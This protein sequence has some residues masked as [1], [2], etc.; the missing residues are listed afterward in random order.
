ME[1]KF[2]AL[3]SV[4]V[5]ISCICHVTGGIASNDTHRNEDDKAKS[6]KTPEADKE[7]VALPRLHVWN[8]VAGEEEW[9]IS[10]YKHRENA[11]P[12]VDPQEGTVAC[13]SKEGLKKSKERRHLQRAEKL[14]TDAFPCLALGEI[15]FVAIGRQHFEGNDSCQREHHGKLPA[16]A[17]Q[18]NEGGGL[19]GDSPQ[20]IAPDAPDDSVADFIQ[21]VYAV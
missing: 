21:P 7:S 4:A 12:L 8:I 3:L 13:S 6:D 16:H 10:G 11:P 2:H 1:L 18:E 15:S 20:G 19:I 9:N 17:N 14:T 5:C